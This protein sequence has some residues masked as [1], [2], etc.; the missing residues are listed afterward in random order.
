MCLTVLFSISDLYFNYGERTLQTVSIEDSRAHPICEIP[1]MIV[2]DHCK[3]VSVLSVLN[4]SCW[5]S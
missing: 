4:G 1:V 5:I 3:L 2:N